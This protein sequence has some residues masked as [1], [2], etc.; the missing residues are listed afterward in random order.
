M[1][2]IPTQ[3][4]PL[5]VVDTKLSLI[6]AQVIEAVVNQEP[7]LT[8]LVPHVVNPTVTTYIRKYNFGQNGYHRMIVIV[9][10]HVVRGPWQ[11]RSQHNKEK[12]RY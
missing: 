9:P 12:E 2:D 4:L 6:H 3:F 7:K 11:L 5:P 8:V 1:H 10:K